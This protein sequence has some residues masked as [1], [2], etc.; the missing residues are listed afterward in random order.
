MFDFMTPELFNIIIVV[1]LI[2]GVTLA[3]WRFRADMK[4]PLYPSRRPSAPMPS[5]QQIR[6][7]K[8]DTQPTSPHK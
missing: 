8:D 7:A 5:V 2:V 6:Q 1:N 3:V 4:R